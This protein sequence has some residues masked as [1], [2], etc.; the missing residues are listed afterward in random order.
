MPWPVGQRKLGIELAMRSAQPPLRDWRLRIERAL[1]QH[2]LAAGL[3]YAQHD[4]EI[5][6]RARRRDAKLKRRGPG[7]FGLA[8]G[9]HGEAEALAHRVVRDAIPAR[10]RLTLRPPTVRVG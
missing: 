5:R 4:E 7:A 3:K 1:E 2:L 9:N 10:R 6:I 8:L